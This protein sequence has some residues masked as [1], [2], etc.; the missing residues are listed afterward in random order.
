VTDADAVELVR[1]L[2]EAFT[3]RD[4]EGVLAV[5]APDLEFHAVT[6]ERTRAGE[7]YRGEEGMREYFADVAR[8]WRELRVIPQSFRTREGGVVLAL[9]RVYARDHEGAIIDSPAGWLLRTR[10]SQIAYVRVFELAAAAVEA[11]EAESGG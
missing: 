4:L 9:G 7:P 2:F 10:G 3:A 11:F 1:R 6:A 8:V 5:A